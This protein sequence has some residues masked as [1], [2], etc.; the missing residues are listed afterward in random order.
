MC[1]TPRN[2]VPSWSASAA[3]RGWKRSPCPRRRCLPRARACRLPSGSQAPASRRGSAGQSRRWLVGWPTNGTGSTSSK[4]ATWLSA[5]AFRSASA[6]CRKAAKARSIPLGRSACSACGRGRPSA[7]RPR[8][9]C[10][11][12]PRLRWPTHLRF[13]LMRICCNHRLPTAIAS[14]TCCVSM[15][16]SFFF[17][18]SHWAE[19]VATHQ[20]GLESARK[21][22]D[23]F[24]EA[25]MLNNLGMA[26][27]EQRMEGAVGCFERSLA[28]YR[29]IGDV[30]G[31]TRAANNVAKVYVEL[32]RFGDALDAAQR[33][34]AIQRLAGNR[35]GEGVALG[36]LGDASRE[37]GRFDEAIDYLQQA[38]VIFREL[39]DQHAE[40]DAL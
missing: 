27:G 37:L 5:R 9:R 32:R 20:I 19:W 22:G 28:I 29:E 12:S 23:R 11:A 40:A 2:P 35:Y 38:L 36:N 21:L 13:C 34:L 16:L 3:P 15:R 26:F 30:P 7:F 17:R 1:S 4:W 24:A 31:E 14:M 6:A 33:S 25:W 18:R 8:R 10:S 39:S